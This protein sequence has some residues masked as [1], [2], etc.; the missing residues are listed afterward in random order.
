MSASRIDRRFEALRQQDRAALVTFVTAGYPDYQ[1]SAEILKGLPEAG[2]DII[3]LGMPFT[4]PMADGVPIQIASQRALAGGHNSTKTLQM[5]REFRERNQDTLIVLM[6][7]YNPIYC[8]GVER[9]LTDAAAAG[10]DG[11]IVV[12][13]PPEHDNELCVPAREVGIHFIRLATPTTDAARLPGVLVNTSGFLYYVSSNGVTGS[14]A[15]TAEK[16]EKELARIREHTNLPVAVG[17]G[18]RT[19]SQAERIARFA[20]G[21]VVGSAL[22]E[23]IANADNEAQGRDDV[24]SLTRELSVAVREARTTLSVS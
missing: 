20:D 4:D 18:I 1:H 21:V 11:L 15:P 13:L 24:L 16:V 8:Y 2:A 5:V 10:V 6:G 23:C 9:F 19:A 12:D 7:Y 22:V 17:F 3:E 14:V